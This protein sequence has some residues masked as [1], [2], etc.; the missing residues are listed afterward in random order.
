M[1]GG[2]HSPSKAVVAT[3]VALIVAALMVM[4]VGP[5]AR[6]VLHIKG[7]PVRAWQMFAGKSLDVC[8]TRFVE[9]LED[10]SEVELDR[11]A[12]LGYES[13]EKAPRALKHQHKREQV[14]A[15]AKRLCQKLGPGHDVRVR[16]RCAHRKKGWKTVDKAKVN[17]CEATPARPARG[18]RAPTP[19]GAP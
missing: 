10:G 7:V 8:D 1:V 16:R 15:T 13:R 11:F 18:K 14:E 5:C 4:W 9:R 17:Y 3:R 19:K 6:Q 2:S 12:L